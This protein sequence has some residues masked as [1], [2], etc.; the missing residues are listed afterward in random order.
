ML[1]STMTALDPTLRWLSSDE[2]YA[3]SS[4][5]LEM[6]RDSLQQCVNGGMVTEPSKL[7]PLLDNAN[8]VLATQ[9]QPRI[10]NELAEE[11]LTL[12]EQ[13]WQ[14]RTKACPPGGSAQEEPL[15]LIME[16]LARTPG[17]G[18]PRWRPSFP[19]PGR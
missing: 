13:L 17:A 4:R 8:A 7:Q 1:S 16:K 5:I 3:R 9:P 18:M 6:A 12:G 2:R 11:R 19:D 15:R 14:A 10:T